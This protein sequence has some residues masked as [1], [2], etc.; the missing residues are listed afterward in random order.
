MRFS[1]R[2]LEGEVMIDHRAS[3][4]IPGSRLLGEGT[5]FEGKTLSCC[6]C[7]GCWILNPLRTRERHRCFQCGGQYLCDGC[8]VVRLEP[9]YVHRSFDELADMVRS[10]KYQI[11]G[12]TASRPHVIRRQ[13]DG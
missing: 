5:L 3:P 7:R 13:S 1:E 2:S 12:G 4:G 9:D 6:H 11:V 10:G 8:N